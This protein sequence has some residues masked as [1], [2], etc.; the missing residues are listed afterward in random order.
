MKWTPITYIIHFRD[1]S[2]LSVTE[3]DGKCQRNGKKMLGKKY[4]LDLPTAHQI[5]HTPTL[6]P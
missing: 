5:V 4:C 3:I 6:S 1:T 2:Y